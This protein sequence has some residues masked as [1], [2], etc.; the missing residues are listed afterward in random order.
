MK[1]L[2]NYSFFHSFILLFFILSLFTSCKSKNSEVKVIEKWENGNPKVEKEFINKAENSYYY[3]EYYNNG[4]L[5]SKEKYIK[6]KLDGSSK[7]FDEEGYLCKEKRYKNGILDS[8]Y[9]YKLGKLSGPER[10]YHPNGQLWTERILLN[11][12]PLAVVSNFDSTGK[13]MDPGTLQDGYGTIKLYDKKGNL[14]EVRSYRDGR[15]VVKN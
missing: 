11:G 2:K 3:S 10:I 8:E 6:G 4:I 15:E 5:K 1:N 7:F 12:R 14:I 9:S 13:P